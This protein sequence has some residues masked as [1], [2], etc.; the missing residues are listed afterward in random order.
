MFPSQHERTHRRTDFASV[1]RAA[2]ASLNLSSC[3]ASER[4]R[5]LPPMRTFLRRFAV[6][7]ASAALIFFCSCE[8]HSPD[9]LGSHGD[10]GKGDDQGH[11]SKDD[12]KGHGNAGGLANEHG[13]D[14]SKGEAHGRD[15]H[16]KAKAAGDTHAAPVSP[17]AIPPVANTP[18][19]FFPP[20]TPAEAASSPAESPR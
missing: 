17:Q 1:T 15:G 14:H 2:A 16:G 19:Q 3:A 10:H 18:A 12:A 4:T 9:E 13:D 7:S 6:V 11:A 20:T 8:R 5:R